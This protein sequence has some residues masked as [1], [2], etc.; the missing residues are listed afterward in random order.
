MLRVLRYINLAVDTQSLN[1]QE[2]IRAQKALNLIL[3]R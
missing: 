1:N 3:R 2:H